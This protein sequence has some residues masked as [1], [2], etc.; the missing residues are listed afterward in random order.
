MP[1]LS[2]NGEVLHYVRTG[3]GSPLLLIH[4]L[5]TGSWMWR[6][7]I[8]RWQG[9]FDVIAFDARGHGR[10][11]RN[12]PVT[13]QAIAQDL[14]MTVDALGLSSVRV[15]AISMGGPILCRLYQSLSTRIER[16]VIADSFARQGQAGVARVAGLAATLESSSMHDYA[17]SYAEGTLLPA[18][19]GW[20]FEQL[21]EGI[22][23]MDK[24]TYLEI[25][26]SVFTS[27][28]ADLMRE[29]VIPVLVVCGQ[30][31]SR[32]PIALSE[33]VVS[34]LPNARMG[35]IPAAAHLA[36]LD[37]PEGFHTTVDPFLKG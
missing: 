19:R 8:A 10:S 16:A 22:S 11:T 3:A 26:R 21:V 35:I 2:V 20:A 14:A 37:N 23:S 28:V 30:N 15:V 25:A 12:G 9:D 34:L 4:S 24:A 36:N 17:L 31:D 27:D 5:A 7:Q 32:T 13:V 33:E 6:D 18:T 1:E 29:M